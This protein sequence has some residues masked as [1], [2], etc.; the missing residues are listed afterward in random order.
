MNACAARSNGLELLEMF[1]GT[2]LYIGVWIGFG[3]REDR[4]IGVYQQV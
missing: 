3:V 4:E 1:L 2:E